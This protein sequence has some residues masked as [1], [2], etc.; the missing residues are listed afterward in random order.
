MPAPAPPTLASVPGGSLAA[1]IGGINSG[2]VN[3]WATNGSQRGHIRYDARISYV[4]AL[5]E[6]YASRRSF[7]SVSAGRLLV[8]DSPIPEAGAE[9][10]NVYVGIVRGKLVIKGATNTGPL[11]GG[12]LNGTGSFLQGTAE[13]KQNVAPIPIGTNWTEPPTGLVNGPR[14]PLA[15]TSNVLGNF[16]ISVPPSLAATFFQQAMQQGVLNFPF[17]L[18]ATVVT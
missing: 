3:G 9:A 12:A 13:T 16:I 2:P 7:L 10:Y 11:N 14:L 15:N 4:S 1:C 5:G 18:S 6:T 8:V 17:Q